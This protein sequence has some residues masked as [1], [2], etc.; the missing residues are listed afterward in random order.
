[1]QTQS[2][3]ASGGVAAV[4]AVAEPER[5]RRLRE[6][7]MAALLWHGARH[8]LVRAVSAAVADPEA[9]PAALA[10]LSALSAL[11]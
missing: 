3:R 7:R 8:P 2:D 10:A 1:M 6:L 4:F 5:T 11:P 9:I